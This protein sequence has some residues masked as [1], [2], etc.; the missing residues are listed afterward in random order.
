MQTRHKSSTHQ[1]PPRTA[2]AQQQ[3]DNDARFA[4]KISMPARKPTKK[5]GSGKF[6][7]RQ[8]RTS[9]TPKRLAFGGVGKKKQV[10]KGASITPRRL[11]RKSRGERPSAGRRPVPMRRQQEAGHWRVHDDSSSSGSEAPEEATPRRSHSRLRSLSQ[12]AEGMAKNKQ[13]DDAQESEPDQPSQNIWRTLPAAR[14]GC[15]HEREHR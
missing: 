11:E 2:E 4:K 14:E 3:I 5:G 10:Q 8:V 1:R 12:A 13:L 6:G 7:S 15:M 9:I